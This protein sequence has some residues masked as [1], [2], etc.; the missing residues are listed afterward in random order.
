MTPEQGWGAAL[1][2]GLG[3]EPWR[4]PI[5]MVSAISIY[6]VFLLLT[7]LFGQRILTATT[8]LEAVVVVMFGAV[9][10][11]VIIGEPPSLA[12]GAIGLC[13][14]VIMELVFGR[15]R[16]Y[17]RRRSDHG[18]FRV[19]PVLIVAHGKAIPQLQRKA[20]VSREDIAVFLRRNG[21][22]QLSQVRYMILESSGTLS[23]IRADQ[24]YDPAILA[25][26][27]GAAEYAHEAPEAQH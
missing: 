3:I 22:T 13:T 26:V 8:S 21:L 16:R 15:I 1:V 24:P 27:V 5:V 11:R 6:L 18:I 7:R 19:D 4:I 23:I 25:G 9:A 14:L 20:R 10:G 2:H 17:A 12:A